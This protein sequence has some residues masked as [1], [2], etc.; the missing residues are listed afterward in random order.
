M[1]VFGHWLWASEFI[2]RV[3]VP[4]RSSPPVHLRE[5]TER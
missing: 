4:E 3:G 5:T 1:Q 2:E